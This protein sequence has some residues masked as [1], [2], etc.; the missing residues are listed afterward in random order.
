[1]RV[2]TGMGDLLAAAV[3]SGAVRDFDAHLCV[4]TSSWLVCH[5]PFKKTDLFHNMASLPSGIPGRY[6][7]TNEQ[8]S[9]GVCLQALKDNV[10][11]A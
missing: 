6:L 7:L 2:A 8:E 11:L 9:A 4:G 10:L 5:V 3:G 1:M